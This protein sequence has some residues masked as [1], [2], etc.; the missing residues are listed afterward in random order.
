[1]TRADIAALRL[2]NQHLAR[3]VLDDPAAVARRLVAVQSQE[4]QGGKWTVGQRTLGAT[5]ASL[6]DAFNAGTILRT[7]VMRPTW[8]FVAPDDIRWL[9]A[10]TGPRVHQL[11]A[12]LCRRLELDEA[13]LNRS[14]GIIEGMLERGSYRTRKQ[15]AEA[16]LH[17]GIRTDTLR[18][19][20]IVMWME[21]EGIVCSG[22]LHGKQHTYAL[23]EE[24]APQARR[25]DR[26][27]ALAELSLRYFTTRGPA[28]PQDFSWWSGLTV[29]DARRGAQMAAAGLLSETVDGKTYY[30]PPTTPD[31]SPAQS[32]LLPTYDELLLGYKDRTAAALPDETDA[33]LFGS[34]VVS[35]EGRVVGTWSREVKPKTVEV[36]LRPFLSTSE[37][38]VALAKEAAERYAAFHGRAL[39]LV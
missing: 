4:Y 28:T 3:P 19:A 26:D 33:W 18:L 36:D 15:I 16:L 7:H 29:A 25:L 22:P 13:V 30:L 11:N 39:V 24:R 32:F 31:P 38:A 8:H 6:D 14:R 10:L 1:M 20:Y 23:I 35:P 37:P 27:E 9:Q 5:D 2:H 34:S 17:A 12:G 21:L